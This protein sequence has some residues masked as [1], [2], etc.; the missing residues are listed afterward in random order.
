R[1]GADALTVTANAGST[2]SGSLVAPGLCQAQSSVLHCQGFFPTRIE[3]DGTFGDG[4]DALTVP[5]QGSRGA[6]PSTG[7]DVDMGDGTDNV[8]IA[9]FEA[10][11]TG[12]VWT[13]HAGAGNDLIRYHDSFV[14]DG[15]SAATHDVFD[16]GAGND[17]LTD[18]AGTDDVV[19]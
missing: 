7:G 8:A 16:L 3:I 11:R 1:Q 14:E 18:D 5:D 19:D 17:D 9:H 6:W 12:P 13:I 10:H 4:P 2:F 15:T